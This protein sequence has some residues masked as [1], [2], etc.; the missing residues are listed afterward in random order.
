[1]KLLTKAA[2]GADSRRKQVADSMD[3][4]VKFDRGS[5]WMRSPFFFAFGDALRHKKVAFFGY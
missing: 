3:S 4:A 5:F 1:M 2:M